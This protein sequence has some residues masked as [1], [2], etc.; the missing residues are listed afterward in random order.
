MSKIV[1]A[2]FTGDNEPALGVYDFD[3]K[4][5]DVMIS[6]RKANGE[7]FDGEHRVRLTLNDYNRII[8]N[9]GW[10]AIQTGWRG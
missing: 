3:P 7:A 6:D 8:A 9:Y 4:R 5:L 1:H 2:A 10:P